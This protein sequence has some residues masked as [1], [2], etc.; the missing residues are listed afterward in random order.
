[1]TWTE[2]A[3]LWEAL[4]GFAWPVVVAGGLFGFRR[5]LR[6]LLGRI[7]TLKGGGL[8]LQTFEDEARRVSQTL[9]QAQ[10][11]IVQEGEPTLPT[12]G[13]SQGLAEGSPAER[14]GVAWSRVEE[15]LRGLVVEALGVAEDDTPF[16][17]TDALDLVLARLS[18]IVPFEVSLNVL[19]LGNLYRSVTDDSTPVSVTA[20]E[21]YEMAAWRARSVLNF[22]R[23]RKLYGPPHGG[24]TVTDGPSGQVAA[25]DAD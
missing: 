23:R 21:Q 12:L 15:E 10:E 19:S 11:Q 3:A 4:D 9:Q 16:H 22:I 7:R 6:E 2:A 8:E 17:M 18:S 13:G 1:M 25:Q 14:V 5:P 24:L 20:A